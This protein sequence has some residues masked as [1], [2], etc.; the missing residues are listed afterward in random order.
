[1][2]ED[3]KVADTRPDWVYNRVFALFNFAR[4]KKEK[5]IP[6]LDVDTK[7]SVKRFLDNGDEQFLFFFPTGDCQFQATCDLPGSTQLK[8]K[9]AVMY[10]IAGGGKA[11]EKVQLTSA[12]V[13]EK[14]V[15][16]EFTKNVM[17]LLNNYC[18]SIYLSTL[19]NPANQRGW[20]DLISKDLMDKYHVFLANLH[21][22]VGLMSG[23]TLL[24]LPPKEAT[25]DRD[26]NS[27]N[28]D[29]VHVLEG[30]VI[31]W[32]KQISHVLKQDPEAL[33]KDGNNPD[34]LVELAFWRNKAANLNKI[35]T[36][37]QSEHL[38]K[39]LKFLEQNKSTYTNPFSKLQKDVEV[40][41]DEASDTDHFLKTLKPLFEVLV[42]E[43]T[44]FEK[45]DQHFDAILHTILLIWKYSKYYNTPARLV[46]LMREI[47]N[48]IITQAQRY[49]SGP[50]IFSMI[51]NEEAKEAVDKLEKTLEICTA[52]RDKYFLYKDVS[53]QQSNGGWKIQSNALFVRLDAFRE[54]CRDI[55]DFTKTI[56][57]FFKL[58]RIDIGGTKGKLLT[59]TIANIYEEFKMA[60][61][62]FQEVDYDIMDITGDAKKN[63]DD[64]FFKFRC[65]IKE[66]DR[67]LAT[68]LSLGFDD[69]DTVQGR[70]KLFDSFEGLL[71]RPI[72][73]DELEAKYAQLLS[74]CRVDLKQCKKLFQENRGNVDTVSDSAPL[75]S[76]M[77][78]IAGAIYW[79]RCLKARIASPMSKLLIFNKVVKERPDEFREV[80]KLYNQLVETLEDYELKKYSEW[81][82]HAVDGAK[83][84][85]KM[86]LLRRVEKTGLL[87]VNFDPALVRL[88]REV[89]YFLL[90]G[91]TVPQAALDIYQ[92]ANVYRRWVGQL[93]IVVQKYNA[94]LT[95]LLPVE[96]P[97]LDEKIVKMDSVLSP[98]LTDL[99]WKSEDRIPEFITQVSTVVGDVSS[100]VDVI[101]GNLKKISSIIEKWCQQPLLERKQKPLG[102]EEFELVHKSN[103][104]TKLHLMS[105]EGKEIHKFLKDSAEALKVPKSAPIWKN[106]VDFVT[107]IM[108]E[109]FVSV[110]AVSLQY[111]CEILDPLIISRHEVQPLFDIK[112]EL[113]D[114]T[115]EIV[116][117]PPFTQTPGAAAA[118]YTLRGT[119]QGWLRD[120][121]SMAALTMVRL[122]T[123]VGDYLNEMK[124]HFQMQCLLALVFELID[125]TEMKCIEYRQS[126]MQHS[127]LW[128]ES[129]EDTFSEF[130]ADGAV[131]LVVGVEEEGRSFNEI[132]EKIG[133][134]L[135]TAIPPLAKF[136][137]QIQRFKKLKEEVANMKTPT[138]PLAPHQRP[139]GESASRTVHRKV[140]DKI[141]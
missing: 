134:D 118:A 10:K 117:D 20:S 97:L 137:E 35:H 59:A 29:R 96:E 126:F 87:K 89:R 85:L 66:L 101:K 23:L 5:A 62:R 84:K 86:R 71:E 100:V 54:R 17:E 47:C 141:Q 139:T 79:S 49:I 128:R 42:S 120:F 102:V 114:S 3:K 75:F 82:R 111:L 19:S 63:F 50:Q 81:Q 32:T 68:V 28:K 67:R 27:N 132:M 109:G 11:D 121:F 116:F 94:V 95:E 30:A 44:E 41:R 52:F 2:G 39:V 80:D 136:D 138:D 108:I 113:D 70:L 58:E 37:L 129:I 122:D 43:S 13:H 1:M 33:I 123:G 131:D 40:A 83:D 55:L 4:S 99:R 74:S 107:N 133:I 124:E 38:K 24:P 51:Q 46:V 14:V 77:P 36:Q 15:V 6:A 65:S 64:D 103:V 119:V 105:E 91:L 25:S 73:A 60:V 53:E 112:I 72:L 98:G 78:P 45:L 76:N 61:T 16:L 110:I 8:K 18:H 34:P 106:Y 93:D 115:G 69:L 130:L 125:N 22:T 31:T 7:D 88:L 135:G 48:V 21:V 127:F 12:N 140:G 26:S 9:A 104:G 57:Q 92:N 90:F 56:V